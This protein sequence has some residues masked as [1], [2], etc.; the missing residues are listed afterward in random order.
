MIRVDWSAL[1]PVWYHPVR[2]VEQLTETHG[3]HEGC[4][5]SVRGT[6]LR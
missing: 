1:Q 2:F 4:M 6:L 5:L 3:G